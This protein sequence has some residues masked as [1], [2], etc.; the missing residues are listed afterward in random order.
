MS[1]IITYTYTRHAISQDIHGTMSC[2]YYVHTCTCTCTQ[3]KICTCRCI[4][5]VIGVVTLNLPA[6]NEDLIFVRGTP[7]ARIKL[8]D[9]CRIGGSRVS[10]SLFARVFSLSLFF[11]SF[12][13]AVNCHVAVVYVVMSA[14]GCVCSHVSKRPCMQSCQQEAVYAFMSVPSTYV[15]VHRSC[16]MHVCL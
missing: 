12:H 1:S 2:M 6:L 8:V 10:V 7:I 5:S 16:H 3:T 9:L 13:A 4:T 15:S 14:R 11:S